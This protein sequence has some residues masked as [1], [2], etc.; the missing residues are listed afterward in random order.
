ML[1]VSC[2]DVACRAQ[3][4][5]AALAAGI[6]TLQLREPHGDGRTIYDAAVLLRTWTR[7]AGAALV[8]NDRLDVA[9]ASEADGAHLPVAS[10]PIAV[11]RQ[12]L[13]PDAWIGRSTHASEEAHDAAQAGADYV[14]LGPI[15]DTP[16]KRTYGPPLGP[17]T[18]HALSLPVPLIAIGG[19][20]TARTP[21]VIAAGADGIAVIREILE[22]TDPATAAAALV[23]AARPRPR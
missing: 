12:V 16:S 17:N 22:A 5:Q 6:D 10:F 13:G 21:E 19:I 9:R 14:V 23:E 15:Y 20:T 3:A 2:D 4:I 11:A 18:L 1:V 8:V 7:E